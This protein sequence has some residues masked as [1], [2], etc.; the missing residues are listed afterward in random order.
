MTGETGMNAVRAKV[1]ELDKSMS[2]LAEQM[3]ITR[4][5]VGQ[6]NRVPAERVGTVGTILELD[7][8]I[9]R[10]DLFGAGCGG[11][12]KA[13]VAEPSETEPAP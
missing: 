13:P 3:S 9:L 7:P 4:G 5:A 10:P 6:W 12:S 8:Q 2:W 11:V 1:K